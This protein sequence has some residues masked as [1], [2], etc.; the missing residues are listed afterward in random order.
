MVSKKIKGVRPIPVE[1]E[2][3][4]VPTFAFDYPILTRDGQVVRRIDMT[5]KGCEVTALHWDDLGLR[6][7]R[8]PTAE[9]GRDHAIHF[10]GLAP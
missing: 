6:V 1:E 9:D 10:R 4:S 3:G 7:V 5:G 2:P 8:H